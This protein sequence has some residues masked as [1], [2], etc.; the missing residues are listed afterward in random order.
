MCRLSAAVS[1]CFRRSLWFAA[2]VAA[3]PAAAGDPVRSF[4]YDAEVRTGEVEVR[5]GPGQRYHVTSMLR[6]HDRVTVHRHDPGGWYMIAPPAGSFSWIDAA[7]VRRTGE[8]AGVVE[9]PA[10]SSVTAVVHIGS[11]FSSELSAYGRELASGD[12]VKVLGEQTL[13]TPR[14]AVHMFKI[15]P[16]AFEYRWVKGEYIVAAG[17]PAGSSRGA[18]PALSPRL[19]TESAPSRS[20]PDRAEPDPFVTGEPGPAAAESTLRIAAGTGRASGGSPKER[21]MRLDDRYLELMRQP[22]DQ[23]DLDDLMADYDGLRD[24]ADAVQVE[25]IDQRLQALRQRRKIWED[26]QAFVRL[27]RETAERDA[28]L[29]AEQEA[30][31]EAVIV[32]ASGVLPSGSGVVPAAGEL[33][34]PVLAP[35]PSPLTTLPPQSGPAQ[36]LPPQSAPWPMFP[37]QSAPLPGAATPT[38]AP[39]PMAGPELIHA[40]TGAGMI[41]RLPRPAAGALTHALVDPQGRVLALL[42]PASGLDLEPH[43]GR[44]IGVIGPRGFDPRLNV[45][46]IQV[47]QL[48]PVQLAR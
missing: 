21:L 10:D 20:V 1:A 35:Q 31:Q 9:L 7:L 32:P 23:W 41:Q 47:R 45:D 34:G 2:L 25:V 40:L 8:S 33:T 17:T 12:A 5:S 28:A 30:A 48:T 27:T 44:P 37:P 22:P 19:T 39:T 38:P 24:V 3:A 46:V 11:E 36:T 15:A 4:P 42:H 6:E 43:V 13:N 18:S 16:P 14:G 29:K 26:Y